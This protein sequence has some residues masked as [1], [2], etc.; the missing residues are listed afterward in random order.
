MAHKHQRTLAFI[1]FIPYETQTYVDNF[2]LGHANVRLRSGPANAN[3]R[4]RSLPGE[5]QRA[6]AIRAK[7]TATHVCDE[8]LL[9]TNVRLQLLTVQR[10]R[11]F[12]FFAW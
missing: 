6:L 1:V 4:W 3:V 2:C 9:N 5:R 10:Q 8:P 7:G 12:T 11:T